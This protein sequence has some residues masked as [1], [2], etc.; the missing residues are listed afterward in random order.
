MQRIAPLVMLVSAVSAGGLTSYLAPAALAALSL[1]TPPVPNTGVHSKWINKTYVVP[2]TVGTD[3]TPAVVAALAAGYNA[4]ATILFKAGVTYNIWTPLVF[5]GLKN[6]EIAFEG[7]ITLPVD[8]PTVQNIVASSSF[9][10]HW[11]KI[12]G[13]NVTLRGSLDPRT[14]WIDSHGTQWWDAM[15]QVNRPHLI[16]VG[17]TNGIIRNIKIKDSIAWNFAVSSSNN[18]HAYGN[19]IDARQRSGG[20]FPFNTDGFAAGGK[21]LL[22]ENNVIMNGDDCL[23][24]GSGGQNVVFRNAYCY[25]GHGL[26]IGSLGKGGSV[27]SVHD[28]LIE[29]VIMDN[30]LYGARFKSW[31]GGAGIA[32]N[33][34][35]RKIIVQNVPF[36][37]YVTQN[38]WD[39]GI[40]PKPDP[41]NV[42]SNTHV[43]GFTF[44]NFSGTLRDTPYV[45]GSCVSDP[46]WYAV[47]GATGHETIIFD[48]YPGTAT[49]IK[50]KNIHIRTQTG[51]RPEV[52]C[53]PS[54]ITSSPGFKCRD[55]TYIPE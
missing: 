24:V 53:D 15:N 55:G 52:M 38:Y 5:S 12:S 35:W 48:L 21:N 2:H 13:T 16:N 4:N 8:V 9:P 40:G 33:I 34:T 28:I 49:T 32:Q 17:V 27:A 30:E 23:T 45:E 20:G 50:A 46:C 51:V 41:G 47:E 26:S 44:E 25:G 31:T 54:T 22:I 37:I 18:L 7:N 36:P 6:V 1:L 29:N 39:Q 42:T 3:D 43:D 11:F 14:G 10:G 19:Y